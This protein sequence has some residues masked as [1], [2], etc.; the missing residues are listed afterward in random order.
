MGERKC[1]FPGCDNKHRAKGLCSSHWNQQKRGDSLSPIRVTRNK[2]RQKAREKETMITGYRSASEVLGVPRYQLQKLLKDEQSALAAEHAPQQVKAR[3]PS[4]WSWAWRDSQHLVDWFGEV[5]GKQQEGDN[6]VN[7]NDDE[8]AVAP[9]PMPQPQ[10]V[11]LKAASLTI[12]VSKSLIYRTLQ[13]LKTENPDLLPRMSKVRDVNKRTQEA[14]TWQDADTLAAWWNRVR[15]ENPGTLPAMLN[16]S[17]LEP[18]P[19]EPTAPETPVKTGKGSG[20]MTADSDYIRSY[21]PTAK[22]LKKLKKIK[23]KLGIVPDLKLSKIAKVSNETI[24]R[25]R[26]SLGI[27]GVMERAR[28]EG[29]RRKDQKPVVA[30]V[31]P[32]PPPP[33]SPAEPKADEAPDGNEVMIRA[34]LGDGTTEALKGIGE[35][36]GIEDLKEILVLTVALGLANWDL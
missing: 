3:G 12:G 26:L 28:R 33:T 8:G 5:Q 30:A 11:G 10:I 24:R 2:Q 7:N 22:T 6:R 29:T 35:E 4:G 32:P 19:P 21:T 23:S 36:H 31:A 13:R 1:S 20:T 14:Y 17:E 16:T 18:L 9:A 34:L 27:E 25:Y 15:A